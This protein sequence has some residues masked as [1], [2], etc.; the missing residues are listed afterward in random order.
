MKRGHYKCKHPYGLVFSGKYPHPNNEADF[1]TWQNS[2]EFFMQDP[3][4]S[5]LQ[6]SRRILYSL[7]SPALDIIMPLGSQALL[8]ACINVLDSAYGTMKDG[9][10]L[11][12]KFLN[13]M[14]NAGKKPSMYCQRLQVALSK[15]VRGDT[16]SADKANCY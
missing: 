8:A 4:L 2:I 6:R 16:I 12:A 14:Q 9:D 11:F 7:P 1:E 13:T 5:N 10:E 15:A 3:S